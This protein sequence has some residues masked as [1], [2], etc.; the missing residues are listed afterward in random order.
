MTLSDLVQEQLKLATVNISQPWIQG[1]WQVGTTA[2]VVVTVINSTGMPLRDVTIDLTAW[3]G[4]ASVGSGPWTIA[5]LAPGDPYHV[6][7]A[8]TATA[9][10]PVY[11]V[12]WLSAEVVPY[13]GLWAATAPAGIP[14]S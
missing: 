8:V 3:Y 12:A 11:L 6:F 4:G 10:V 1:D 13:G 14:S 9:S 2:L 5:E 7:F